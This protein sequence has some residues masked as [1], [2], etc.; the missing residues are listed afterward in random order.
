M[1]GRVYQEKIQIA[2]QAHHGMPSEILPLVLG[3]LGRGVDGFD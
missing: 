2:I 3:A 1:V